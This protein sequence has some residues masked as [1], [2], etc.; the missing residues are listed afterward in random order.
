MQVIRWEPSREPRALDSQPK[1]PP[2]FVWDVPLLTGPWATHPLLVP[3]LQTWLRPRKAVW[4]LRA[5][6]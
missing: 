1:M 4:T 2:F 5:Q 3:P 6:L